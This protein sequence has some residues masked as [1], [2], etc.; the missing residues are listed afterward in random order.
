M[1]GDG[2]E[3]D[4]D[5][6][7]RVGRHARERADEHDQE[8]D[9]SAGRR[10]HQLAD[11]RVHHPRALGRPGAHHRDKRHGHHAEALEVRNERREDEPD[12]LDRQQAVDRDGHLAK[13]ELRVLPILLVLIEDLELVLG[14]VLVVVGH[15]L[16][17]H[18]LGNRLRHRDVG[19]VE[20]GREHD[21]EGDQVQEH[22]YRMGHLVPDL[23]DP[24]QHALH[25][26]LVRGHRRWRSGL[27]HSVSPLPDT[28]TRGG[29]AISCGSR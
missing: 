26:R 28:A 9:Q 25:E 19:Q 22:Q 20:D 23:L 3:R 15:R 4:E 13:L 1:E 24:V 21:D 11:E 5:Q 18:R 16:H 27:A 10:L 14:R 8:R 29:T 2:G 12:S 17:R 6:V 7:P